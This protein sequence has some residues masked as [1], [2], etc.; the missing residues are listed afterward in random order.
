MVPVWLLA[1]KD[2][3]DE[4]KTFDTRLKSRSQAAD[5]NTI[6]CLTLS[7]FIHSKPAL[8]KGEEGRWKESYDE[9]ISL[10]S[11]RQALVLLWVWASAERPQIAVAVHQPQVPL[12]REGHQAQTLSPD[13]HVE[14]PQEQGDSSKMARQHD[15]VVGPSSLQVDL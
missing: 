12:I 7:V 6:Q 10:I 8:M 15:A 14:C 9:T 13:I 2:E 11:N 1:G 5:I 4:E 3:K